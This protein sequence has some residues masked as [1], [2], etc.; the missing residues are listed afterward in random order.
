[1]IRG[2]LLHPTACWRWD[3]SWS[4]LH[5]TAPDGGRF[6]PGQL[7]V[8]YHFFVPLGRKPPAT[9]HHP[10][11]QEEPMAVQPRPAVTLRTVT[12]ADLPLVIP[13]LSLLD[14]PG[15]PPMPLAQAEALLGRMAQYPDYQFYVAEYDGRA[16]GIYALLIMDH[17]SHRG[18]PI[19]IVESVAVAD[20]VRGQGIGRQLMRH[21]MA[22]C[23]AKGC[24]KL[25][26]S[27]NR[28]RTEAHAFYDSLGFKRHGVSFV[29]EL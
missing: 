25:A 15:T 18:M 22:Q 26:L 9:R 28:M 12:P 8:P 21:A 3:V 6:V 27:S 14:Q 29:V 7:P 13:L 10:P 19:G 2:L 24:Y 16:V 23:R 5:T 4:W 20:D 1:M 11:A 17:L